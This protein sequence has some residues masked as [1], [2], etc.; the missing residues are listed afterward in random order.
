MASALAVADASSPRG[1]VRHVRPIPGTTRILGLLD[2]DGFGPPVR[3]HAQDGLGIEVGRVVELRGRWKDHASIGPQFQV[4]DARVAL[5]D[6]RH[7]VLAYI[8]ANIKGCGPTRAKALVDHFGPGVLDVLAQSPE[9]VREVFAARLGDVLTAQWTAWARAYREERATEALLVQIMGFGLSYVMARRV[10][11]HFAELG[12]DPNVVLADP[13]QLTDVRGFGFRR[14][15][16]IALA[17]GYQADSPERADAGLAHVLR[18]ALSQ[19]HSGLPSRLLVRRARKVL[20]LP[21]KAL[22]LS[23]LQVALTAGRFVEHQSLVMLPAAATAES[24]VAAYVR[25]LVDRPTSPRS[26]L[27]AALAATSS[28]SLLTADQRLAAERAFTTPLSILTGGPGY[29]K[30]TVI[31]TVVETATHL[32]ERVALASP[33]GK[34]AGRMTE[35]TGHPASTIHRLLG[36]Q[37]GTRR[38]APVPADLLVVDEVSMCD[39]PLFSWLL[40]NIDRTR[41]RLLLVGDRNQLPSIGHGKLLAD[42]LDSRAVPALELRTPHRQAEHSL[43]LENAHRILAKQHPEIRNT[44][45]SDFW[46]ADV[47]RDDERDD[48]GFPVRSNLTIQREQEDALLRLDHAVQS[49]VGSDPARSDLQVLSPMRRGILGVDSLNRRLQDLLNPDGEPGPAIGGGAVVRAGDRVIQTQNDYQVL[50]GLYNGDQ[51]VVR[52]VRPERQQVVVDFDGRQ[53]ALDASQLQ[54][55]RLAWA[56][57]VHRAQGSEYGNVILLYHTVHQSMLD[58]SLLYTAITRARK[59][60]VLI[61]NE[62][63]LDLTRRVGPRSSRRYTSLAERLRG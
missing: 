30:T 53:V 12:R 3:F 15:D 31:R 14:V 26:G 50:G 29:G 35:V 21:D 19:G 1:V 10:E 39:V 24:R 33:T 46:F 37:F 28:A 56:I 32:G 47:T 27:T 11:R 16:A 13:Y 18:A 9:R 62:R 60:F 54:A 57:T 52:L 59:R 20:A 45:S 42:L 58:T 4:Q 8:T 43:I 38:P 61:G 2:P 49:L 48:D 41:T 40:A 63:A 51:G 55:L 34:A 44:P 7:G 25:E 22:L 17:R 36:V 5:P 23:R 6:V